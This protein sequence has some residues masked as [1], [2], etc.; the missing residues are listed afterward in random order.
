MMWGFHDDYQVKKV[1]KR[2]VREGLGT[3]GRGGRSLSFNHHT[4]R[5]GILLF[6]DQPQLIKR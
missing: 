3:E 2:E 5:I 6:H 1:G 4:T